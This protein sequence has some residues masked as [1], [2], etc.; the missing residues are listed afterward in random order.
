MQQAV[1]L[2]R[3]AGYD[4]V[5]SIP[6][7]DYANACGKID[8]SDYDGSTWLESR[9]RD[10]LGQLIA[11]AH[12]YGKNLCDTVS[13]LQLEHASDNE[14]G[15]NDLRRDRGD[16]RRL[17][18]RLEL[19]LYLLAVGSRARRR[20]RGLDVGHVGRLRRPHLG[21]QR[22]ARERVGE[23]GKSTILSK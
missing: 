22:N 7:I 4:G 10:P 2:M 18:L 6:C 23:L 14:E 1:N 5:I 16:I 12:V 20:I 11:E 19:Y 3:K 9:P 13:L 15:A 17:G 8:G 21:L